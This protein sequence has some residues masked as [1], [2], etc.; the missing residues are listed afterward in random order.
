MEKG[1]FFY[2]LLE[3]R[4]KPKSRDIRK[5]KRRCDFEIAMALQRPFFENGDLD[6]LPS[7]LQMSLS[8]E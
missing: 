3:N 6:I 8:L 5:K 4:L 1:K 2:V 7:P